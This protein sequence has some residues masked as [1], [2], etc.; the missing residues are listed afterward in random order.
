MKKTL[1][2][3][4]LGVLTLLATGTASAT[5]LGFTGEAITGDFDGDGLDELAQ[6]IRDDPGGSGTFYHLLVMDTNDKGELVT[7]SAFVGD[8]VQ[9]LNFWADHDKGAIGLDLVQGG[10][11]DAACCPTHK[12]V[13]RWKLAGGKLTELTAEPYGQVSLGDLVRFKWNLVRME[14]K[15]IPEGVDIH[16][17][18]GDGGAVGKSGCNNYQVGL[19]EPAPGKVSFQAPIAATMM[20]CP[21][22]AMSLE[23]KYLQRLSQVT[24]YRWMGK[25]LALDWQAEDQGGSLLFR[26]VE[27]EE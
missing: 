2:K 22:P 5:G 4:L 20:A 16:L 23:Q 24:G 11:G 8:R 26:L 6:I 25:S 12:V 7:D 19:K 21:E 10:E 14:E 3:M 9:V 15:A 18:L 27:E 13:R 1:G 17:I